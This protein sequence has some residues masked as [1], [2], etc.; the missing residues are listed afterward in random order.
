V[1]AFAAGRLSRT[2]DPLHSVV[3]FA[4][5]ANAKFGELG[6]PGRMQYFASRSAPMGAVSAKVVAAAFFNFNPELV[7]AS[8]PAACDAGALRGR[9]HNDA[10]GVGGVRPFVGDRS[11]CGDAAPGRRGDFQRRRPPAVRRSAELD[12]PDTPH[13]PLWH[14]IT[15]LREYRGDGHIAALVTHGLDG[16]E[17]LITHIATDIG[18]SPDFGRRLRGW[19]EEQWATAYGTA[20]SSTMRLR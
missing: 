6:M 9:R 14:A 1:D 12:W 3:C 15:L 20:A 13:G 10:K 17:A 11:G 18:Y 4:P 7:T 19:S 16:L 2:L 5:D 8:I